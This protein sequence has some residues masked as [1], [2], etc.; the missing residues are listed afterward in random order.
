MS[1]VDPTSATT[2]PSASLPTPTASTTSGAQTS[3]PPV[4]TFDVLPALHTLLSR[5]LP[6]ATS[7]EPPL[8]PQHLATEASALKIRL[9]KAR[10]AVERLPDIERLPAE[11]ETEIRTLEERVARQ[12]DVLRGLGERVRAG[13]DEGDAPRR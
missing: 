9:Q 5:L 13:G 3:L 7:T 8:E 6:S 1:P 11:Q 2:P 12:R 10:A 4:S